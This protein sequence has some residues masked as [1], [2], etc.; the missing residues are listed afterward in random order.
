MADYIIRIDT[1]TKPNKGGKSS[2]AWKI[3]CRG[4][5]IAAGLLYFNFHYPNQVFYKGISAALSQLEV[6]HFYSGGTDT[7]K[8]Y[9]DCMPVIDQLCDK[10]QVVKMKKHFKNIKEFCSRHKNVNFE[11]YYQSDEDPEYRKVDKLTR[12]GRDWL[13]KM[14]K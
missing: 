6:D 4:D 10:R 9:G 8:I 3:W 12:V 14:I 11:F 13:Q 7:V 5:I 1:A 2:V